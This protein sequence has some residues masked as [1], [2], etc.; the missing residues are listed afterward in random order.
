MKRY[1]R[2]PAKR[3]FDLAC[4][5]PGLLLMSPLF[6]LVALTILLAEG[7]PVLFVQKR[8]GLGGS[9]FSMY[10]FRTMVTNAEAI[11]GLV[12]VGEDKRVTRVGRFL[13]K[14]KIDEL[15]Q[16][17]NV[18]LGNMSL[19]GPRPEVPRYVELYT[20]EQREVLRLIPGIT[21]PASIKYRNESDLLAGSPDPERTYIDEIMPDKIDLNLQYASRASVAADCLLVLGTLARL[22]SLKVDNEQK[23]TID[24]S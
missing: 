24:R 20:P 15:P 6:A 21:D 9:I 1:T 12:T 11:G 18:I 7:G 3:I 23:A 4:A 17:L 16:L 8:V 5:V 19:V 14:A 22:V 13:R 2:S 10:K